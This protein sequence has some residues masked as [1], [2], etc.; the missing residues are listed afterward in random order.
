M[1]HIITIV[2][3][4][5]LASICNSQ[6]MNPSVN[7]Q[8]T[9]DGIISGSH[10][11]GDSLILMT[12]PAKCAI[13]SVYVLPEDTVLSYAAEVHISLSGASSDIVVWNYE[14]ASSWECTGCK[15]MDWIPSS[16]VIYTKGPD[17]VVARFIAISGIP[18]GGLRVIIS[19]MEML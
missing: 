18:I 2:F 11:E 15:E 7:R 10:L 4:L 12:I 6:V 5:L 16:P 17:F 1:K 14:G 3:L 13:T 8:W 9:Y 19:Y